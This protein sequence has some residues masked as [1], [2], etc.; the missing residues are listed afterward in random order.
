M[1]QPRSLPFF[2]L[3]MMSPIAQTL[4]QGAPTTNRAP[5][6]H[7]PRDVS[8]PR[9]EVEP[10]SPTCTPTVGT[11]HNCCSFRWGV[12]SSGGAHP[13]DCGWKVGGAVRDRLGDAAGPHRTA[14]PRRAAGSA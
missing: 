5:P 9:N 10:T 2:F 12:I 7:H 1:Y 4:S 3:R 8:A 14:G 6:V 11:M 13:L